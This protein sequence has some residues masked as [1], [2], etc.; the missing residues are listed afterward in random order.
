MKYLW[1]GVGNSEEGRA[2]IAKHGG[3]LL[4]AEVSN[5]ALVQGLEMNGVFCDSINSSRL[6]AYPKYAQKKVPPYE[7][8]TPSGM[9]GI[10]V[11]YSNYP[12]INL[13]S[14]K[15]SLIKEAKKWANKNRGEEV[16]VFIY[17][18]HTPFMAAAAAVKKIIPGAK[19]VLIVPDL[20]Q[21]MD[22]N[23]SALK[24]VLKAIDWKSICGYMKC[25]DKYIL[26]SKH[27][28][29][30]LGLEDGKWT[31][32]EG[33]FDPSLVIDGEDV[34]KDGGKIS[35]M[36]SGVLDTRYGIKEL[37]EAM[38]LLDG[39]YELWLTGNGN[40][41]PLIKEMAEKDERIKYYGFLPSRLDLLKK[42]HEA[43]MLISTRDPA[44]EASA[45]CFPSK[46]F[47]YMV[48]E[49]PVIST[50]IKGIPDEYFE[51]MIALPDIKPETLAAKIKYVA[52]MA[53]S[54]REAFGKAAARF[55]I[56]NKNNVAQTKRI[57]EFL[58]IK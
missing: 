37:L 47:E 55:V 41:V 29:E 46:I 39:N 17:Q 34:K 8:V 21:Y 42:Q 58:E 18:M 2:D 20:P 35:V 26:Y 56:E 54:E 12:Y 45:Y 57:L 33:S 1:I 6:P 40:A 38:S 15:K 36:Y 30:F 51:H 5:D 22:M 43:T 52:E 4:S 11:G 50:V 3:K 53:Q 10:S 49:N 9:A 14:K 24:K 32:M 27:M 7:W 19:L 48:S 16:T 13:L 23:M 28:A 44:E 25:V 31:V